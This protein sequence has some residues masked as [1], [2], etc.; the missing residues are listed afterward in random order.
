MRYVAQLFEVHTKHSTI[1]A[2]FA[3]KYVKN[4]CC[5]WE[6][7]RISILTGYMMGNLPK[8]KTDLVSKEHVCEGK[9]D[10][11]LK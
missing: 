11:Y 10:E 2:S 1:Q 5:G 6:K 8:D 7:L 3:H 9:K 4:S